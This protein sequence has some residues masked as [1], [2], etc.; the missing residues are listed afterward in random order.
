MQI[1]VKIEVPRGNHCDGFPDGTCSYFEYGG[2]V[3][4]CAV[5][6]AILKKNEFDGQAFKCQPCLDVCAE[7]REVKA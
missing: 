6:R 7:A 5:F 4:I 2:S 3:R 1:T